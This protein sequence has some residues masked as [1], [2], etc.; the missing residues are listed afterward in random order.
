MLK[1]DGTRFSEKNPVS[2]FLGKKGSNWPKFDVFLLLKKNESLVFSS[3][4]V[5]S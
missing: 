1:S 4:T 2:P 5:N 3:C